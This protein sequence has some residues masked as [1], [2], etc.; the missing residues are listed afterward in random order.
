MRRPACPSIQPWQAQRLLVDPYVT[1]FIAVIC[2]IRPEVI[3]T[4][5]ALATAKELHYV[6]STQAGK[7][8]VRASLPS[9][10]LSSLVSTPQSRSTS[11]PRL[12]ISHVGDGTTPAARRCAESQ[13]PM[14]WAAPVLFDSTYRSRAR[15]C[16]NVRVSCRGR[17]FAHTHSVRQFESSSLR[18]DHTYTSMVNRCVSPKQ[19]ETLYI[20]L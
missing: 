1:Y 15:T 19:F 7:Q 14:P 4:S 3:S 12:G 17:R 8:L 6:G 2:H 13:A 10:M 16:M 11:L 20:S 18:H 9:L 5:P